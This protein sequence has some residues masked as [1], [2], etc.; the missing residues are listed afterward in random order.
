MGSFIGGMREGRF[1]LATAWVAAVCVAWSVP[2]LGQTAAPL[3]DL[4]R[5]VKA[6]MES[7]DSS[8]MS[9]QKVNAARREL[10]SS[11]AKLDASLAREGKNGAAWKRYLRLADLTTAV[12]SRSTASDERLKEILQRFRSD[13]PGLERPVCQAVA[14][15]LEQYLR[16]AGERSQ[17]TTED[18]IKAKLDQLAGLLDD[19]GDPPPAE[20]VA[21]I[22]KILGW[23]SDRGIESDVAEVRT[24]LSQPNLHVQVSQQL[25]GSGSLRRI[26]DTPRPVHD[27]ILGTNIVGTGRTSGWIRT[28]ILPDPHHALFETTITA[29]NRAQSVGYNGPA[30]IGSTSTTQLSGTKRFYV[31]ATGFHVWQATAC[32]EAHSQICG[33]WSSK[34]GLMDR[35]VRR[36]A[37]KRA[38]QQKQTAEQ[39]ASRHAEAQLSARTD[40]EANAQ[41]GRAHADFLHKI[42]YPL[43]R[44]GQ[45]PRELRLTSAADRIQII[46]LHDRS[47]QL[48]SPLAPPKVPEQVDMAVQ[49]HESLVNNYSDGLLAGQT[50]RQQDLDKLS[51]QLF[52]RRPKQ[53]AFDEQKG[54]WEITFASLAPVVLRVDGGRASLTLRGRRFGS[55][56]RTI[57]TPMDVTAHYRFVRE[58]DAAKA[59][60]E[61]DDIEVYPTGFVPGGERRMSLRQSRDASYIRNRFDDFFTPEITSQGLVLPGQWAQAGRLELVELTAD[62]GWVTLAWRQDRVPAVKE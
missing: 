54:P 25:I 27:V 3:A 24:R 62:Q 29:T 37:S 59:V 58:D 33:I 50:L 36:V 46:G 30:R 45:W 39:I 5:Q 1:R 20:K 49:F 47:S 35:I 44:V 42:R 12:Q 31:D 34:H 13:S 55:D 2:A 8:A 18:E 15:A 22:G 21:E 52:G 57:D 6:G 60:R 48:A 9:R 17:A 14:V 7:N 53:I 19:L 28:R 32:A 16:I 56:I 40:K 41:L 4:V 38:G 51:L 10:A 61:G 43:V 23:L 11:L 26:D